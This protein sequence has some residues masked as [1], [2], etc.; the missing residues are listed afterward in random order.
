MLPPTSYTI[1]VRTTIIWQGSPDDKEPEQAVLVEGYSDCIE[2]RQDEDVIRINHETV[3][4]LRKALK[5]ASDGAK[6]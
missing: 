5:D 2:I 6:P 1:N 4:A 3:V